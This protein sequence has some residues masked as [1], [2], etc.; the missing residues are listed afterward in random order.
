VTIDQGD[1]TVEH[2][3]SHSNAAPPDADKLD[4]HSDKSQ[5]DSVRQSALKARERFKKW[6]AGL[7]QDKNS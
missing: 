6:S 7:L 4:D 3:S 5:R 1:K 2:S